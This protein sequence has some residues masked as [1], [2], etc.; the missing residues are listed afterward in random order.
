[1]NASGTVFYTTLFLFAYFVAP[2]MLVWGWE[3]WIK[4]RPR[5]WTI[6]STL[7][8]AGFTLASASALFALWMITY[9][10]GGGF[11]HTAHNPSYSPNYTL[12]YRWIQRGVALSLVAI[13]FALGGVFRPNS[14]RWQAPASAVGTLAF[15]L[16]AT[17]WP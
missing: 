1:M 17:T 16:L 3:R 11:E 6:S 13:A 14:I 12:F 4:Q 8:F 15:W 2:A 5:L 7:S 10:S 9:A